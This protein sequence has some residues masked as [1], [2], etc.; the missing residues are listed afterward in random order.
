MAGASD[1]LDPPPGS[2]PEPAGAAPDGG[3]PGGL[4]RGGHSADPEPGGPVPDPVPPPPG[5]P[6]RSRASRP[7]EVHD[8]LTVFVVRA[9][10]F[11]IAGGIGI[12]CAA[13][14]QIDPFLTMVCA[15]GLALVAIVAEMFFSK[16]PIRTI[17]AI[18]F[19]LIIGLVMSAV[20]QPVIEIM[21]PSLS[22]QG[23]P[24]QFTTIT[25]FLRIIS[26]TLFCYFGV[27]VLLRTKEDFKFI[28]PYVEFRRE[29]KGRDFLILDSSAIIDG[30]IEALLATGV[31]DQ[32]IAVPRFVFD[33]LQV[34]ADSPD[35]S[36]RERG[37]RGM[38]I[39]LR[40]CREFGAEVLERA[41]PPS[42]EV[43]LALLDLVG[44]TG[45]KLVTTDYNLQK[46]A[47][48]QG[49]PVLNLNDLAAALKPAIVPGESLRLK[50]LRPG[51]DP[52]QAV[53]FL[54]DGT[55]V[56]VENA[57]R[58]IGQEVIV[59]VTSAIQTSAGKMVFGRTRRPPGAPPGR[60]FRQG[61][62]SGAAGERPAP[63][64]RGSRGRE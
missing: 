43:D 40:V 16:A 48:L 63:G 31:L 21:V 42:A 64:D 53:G 51:E 2:S 3:D 39:A 20:F 25:Q 8:R 9:L 49:I 13:Q 11:F 14:F 59:E 52:G 30:R 29:V 17:S 19:G 22:R 10:F 55:M 7:G 24:G 61:D 56:V 47:R 32:R 46:R 45:G 37:R 33:E 36:R 34:V 57:S 12:Y 62:R 60:P 41:L 58:R 50:L 6:S 44:G 26:T 4:D 27:T 15:C 35:R 38:D 54:P 18:T 1:R 5:P 23:M 28:I